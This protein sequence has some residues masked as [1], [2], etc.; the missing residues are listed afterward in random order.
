VKGGIVAKEKPVSK[1]WSDLTQW[2]EDA[3]RVVGKEAG[4][5]TLKGRLKLEIFDLNRTL[6]DTFTTLGTTVYHEVFVKK[7]ENWKKT[8][9]VTS[10]IRKIRSTQRKLNVKEKE[11]KKVG[12][13]APK[14]TKR[15][16]R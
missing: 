11:Y 8:K 13:S 3:S 6:R 2:L 15:K 1:M 14:K 9:K 5:L 16:K 4:D 10:T 12:K 7:N